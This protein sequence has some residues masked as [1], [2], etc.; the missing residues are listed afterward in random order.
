MFIHRLK[1][2]KG[3]HLHWVQRRINTTNGIL[4]L[5]AS[6]I[7]ISLKHIYTSNRRWVTTC[8]QSM[9]MDRR[10]GYEQGH[11]KTSKSSDQNTRTR[12]DMYACVCMYTHQHKWLLLSEHT[13]CRR[14]R[15]VHKRRINSSCKV[16]FGL[17][18]EFNL[19]FPIKLCLDSPQQH[20]SAST[21][22][23]KKFKNFYLF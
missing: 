2:T 17:I 5:N 20:F 19:G 16:I 11:G 4:C 9:D 21:W 12:H 14:M 6:Y 3:I 8:L 15:L 10:N 7:C 13:W 23:F 18:T 22:N 1:I